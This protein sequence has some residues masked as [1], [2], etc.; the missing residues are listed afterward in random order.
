MRWILF[1]L[2]LCVSCSTT[3]ALKIQRDYESM[4]KSELTKQLKSYDSGSFDID[5]KQVD[6]N[7]VVS[8][9]VNGRVSTSTVK[10]ETNYYQYA[11]ASILILM[12][13]ACVRFFIFK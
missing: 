7:I 13:L 10:R 3:Q 11:I 9:T 6:G 2:L 8:S 1:V 12:L 5:V 4:S